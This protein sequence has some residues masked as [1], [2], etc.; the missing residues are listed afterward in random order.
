MS[1]T[2]I[3]QTRIAHASVE[4]CEK[5]MSSFLAEKNQTAHSAK[6]SVSCDNCLEYLVQETQNQAK[7][8][9]ELYED[10]D[11]LRKEDLD[12]MH[13]INP[14]KPDSTVWTCFY[15]KIKEV[16]NAHRKNPLP[17]PEPMNVDYYRNRALES[18]QTEKLFTTEENYGRRYMI[19]L[20]YDIIS[21]Y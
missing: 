20:E 14:A 12:F 10:G 2:I 8:A 19:I 4:A 11:G 1:S 5:A 13:G 7:A 15:Q 6:L 9:L 18:D 3:E 21:R 16:K 17:P